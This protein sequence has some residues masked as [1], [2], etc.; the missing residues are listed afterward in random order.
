MRALWLLSLLAVPPGAGSKVGS[1]RPVEMRSSGGLEVDLKRNVGVARG[2]VVIQRED[3]TVCCDEAE[4]RYR[5]KEI[6]R[7][8]CRGRVVVVRKDGTR[9]I[10]D[11]AVFD[12]AK[13]S[14]SL[15]GRARVRSESADV[16]GQLIVY[17]IRSDQLTVKGKDSR[18]R[19]QPPVADTL[20]LPRPCPP[21]R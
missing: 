5:G 2:D 10:A 18:F 13:E 8:E 12:A 4:A 1:E 6:E 7:V 9:A 11:V 16:E 19:F 15:S 17:D 21:Q 3:V 14:V 20:Q